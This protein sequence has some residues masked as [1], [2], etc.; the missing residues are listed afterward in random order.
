MKTNFFHYKILATAIA[1]V[2]LFSTANTAWGASW[3]CHCVKGSSMEW[4]IEDESTGNTLKC[5]SVCKAEYFFSCVN[6]YGVPNDPSTGV[7]DADPIR[8]D[9]KG[10]WKTRCTIE[11]K[12]GKREALQSIAQDFETFYNLLNQ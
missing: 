12:E 3:Y 2:P 1:L 9:L 6:T 11:S 8:Y 4:E 5:R 10:Q 7:E